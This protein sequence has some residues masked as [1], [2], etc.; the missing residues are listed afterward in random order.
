MAIASRVRG[1]MTRSS[2]IRRMFEEG[3]RL[4][5]QHG[6]D[7]VI[8]LSL[9]NP[10]LEPP[11]AFF[12][13]L[14]AAVEEDA[15]RPGLHRYMPNVGFAETRA[16]VAVQLSAESGLAVEADDVVMSVGAA[17]GL[18]VVMKSI[19]EPGDEV[20]VLAPYFP[21][22]EFYVG[23]HGG[24]PLAVPSAPDFGIDLAAVER[25]L[26]RPG[27]RV[28]AL[29]LNSP[30]NPTGHVLR[31]EEIA[32]LGDLL[33]ARAPQ[34]YLVSDEPYRRLLFGGRRYAGVLGPYARAIVVGSHSKDLALPGERIGFIALSPAM[35]AAE[36]RE[37]IAAM[38]FVT[39]TLGFVNA[40]ALMQRV[41][42]GLQG[43]S[44]DPKE[45]EERRDLIC[46]ALAR[47]GYDLVW[48]EGAFYAFPR[49]PEP[50]D[51]RFVTRLAERLVLTVPGSGFGTP[52]Y[53]RISFCM[54]KETIARALPVFA[55]MAR[56]YGLRERS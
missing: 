10:E 40:P 31:A 6:K 13:A 33:R 52:G 47:A 53:F 43:V 1:D 29:I 45:Y 9:G 8:D 37:L 2:W 44:V 36:R 12:D 15:V 21:E 3:N 28:R 32:A 34:V 18:N 26:A 51:V 22:Y 4:R 55:A 23:N 38:A 27:A 56:E 11:R 50:D 7:A 41:V 48:P 5:A 30:N 25:A 19:L 54:A 39:R 20:I 46:H 24:V 42:R 49:S 14:R 16:A 17:G 35:E